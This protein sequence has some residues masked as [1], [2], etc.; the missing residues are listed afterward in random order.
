MSHGHRIVVNIHICLIALFQ[1]R[2]VVDSSPLRCRVDLGNN[3]R[4]RNRPGLQYRIGSSRWKHRPFTRPP[5]STG[6]IVRRSLYAGHRLRLLTQPRLRGYIL[7]PLRQVINKSEPLRIEGTVV[8]HRNRIKNTIPL[9]KQFL[10]VNNQ[11]KTITSPHNTIR[12][13]NLHA[14]P[15]H[16]QGGGLVACCGGGFGAGC[17]GISGGRSGSLRL[18]RDRGSVLRGRHVGCLRAFVSSVGSRSEG[19]QRRDEKRES[20]QAGSTRNAHT[21]TER[22]QSRHRLL[23]LTENGQDVSQRSEANR[24]S[25]ALTE[26]GVIIVKDCNIVEIRFHSF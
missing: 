13:I 26:G 7:K 3:I 16:C 24:P 21:G 9:S 8:A 15:S 2:R 19:C 4:C 20:G 23:L 5:S 25:L 17:V 1:R 22:T 6:P 14:L 10:R 12:G 18:G 11:R